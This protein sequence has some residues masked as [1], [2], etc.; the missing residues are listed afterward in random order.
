MLRRVD[1]MKY[2]RMLRLPLEKEQRSSKRYA[3]DTDIK[4][5]LSNEVTV[6]EKLDGSIVSFSREG[7]DI[8]AYGRRNEIMRNGVLNNRTKAYIMLDDW[9]WNN[10]ESL[11]QIPEGY[12]IFGEWLKAKHTIF[13]DKLSDYWLYFDIFDGKRFLSD[14]ERVGVVENLELWGMPLLKLDY[15]TITSLRVIALRKKSECGDRMEGFVVKNYEKQIFCKFVKREFD[16]D[17]E[18]SAHWLKQP[19]EINRVVSKE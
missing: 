19:L 14:E 1:E 10:V 7:D 9:Y 16:V 18:E 5:L 6:D 17:L 12:T 3:T 2:P 4:E 11:Q 13:Y 8:V 15:L